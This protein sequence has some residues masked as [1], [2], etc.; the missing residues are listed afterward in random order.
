MI[1]THMTGLGPL[2]PYGSLRLRPRMGFAP[3]PCLNPI[4]YVIDVMQ[5]ARAARAC[6]IPRLWKDLLTY[7]ALSTNIA[8]H[9]AT[10][11]DMLNIFSLFDVNSFPCTLPDPVYGGMGSTFVVLER[12]M[13][14]DHALASESFSG[15]SDRD[16]MD[17]PCVTQE[18]DTT[19]SCSMSAPGFIPRVWSR[20][21][22]DLP[23]FEHD[24]WAEIS[25][26]LLIYLGVLVIYLDQDLY[27]LLK[28][29]IWKGAITIL[30]YTS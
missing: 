23:N 24:S 25:D 26:P 13:A 12:A 22:T 1:H 8:G 27:M 17:C 14:F 19:P 10:A 11:I 7:H 18:E 28:Q 3:P 30:P 9:G 16:T 6:S 21:A 29:T 20:V 15:T 2:V 4:T 5:R